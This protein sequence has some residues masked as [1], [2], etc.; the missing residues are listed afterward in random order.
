ML[1]LIHAIGREEGILEEGSRPSRNRNPGDLEY[2]DWMKSFGGVLETPLPG[3]KARFAV[4]PNVGQGYAALR[5]LLTFPEYRG[6][7]V[8]EAINTY[9]PAGENKP[10]AYINN[11]CTWVGCEPTTIIDTLL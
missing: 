10:L 5:H 9:A 3:H 4:F 2:H 7:T 11:I 1:T 6:K 8:A